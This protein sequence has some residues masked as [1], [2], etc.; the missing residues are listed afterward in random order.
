MECYAG[1]KLVLAYTMTDLK[2]ISFNVR[3]L[4]QRTKRRA[5]FH[6]LHTVYQSHIVVLQETHSLPSDVKVWK[7]EWGGEIIFAHSP[8]CNASGV[9]V[10]LPRSRYTCASVMSTDCDD[11]GRFVIADIKVELVRIKLIAVYAPTKGHGREQISFYENIR[12][13]LEA[14]S[15]DEL[16]FAVLCG[17]CNVHLSRLDVATPQFHLTQAAETLHAILEEFHLVDVWRNLHPDTVQCTWRR[18]EPVQQS[19][20]DYIFISQHLIENHMVKS[21]DISPGILSDHSVVT[22]TTLLVVHEKGPGLWRFNNL[23]LEDTE[24]VLNAKK[25]MEQAC[26]AA[27]TYESVNDLGLRLEVMSGQVRSIAIRR[28]KT[29]ARAKRDRIDRITK[30]KDALE[31]ELASNPSPEVVAGYDRARKEMDDIQEENGKRAMLFSGARWFEH[32]ERPTKYFLGLCA[33]RKAGRGITVLQTNDGQFV[34]DGKDILRQC[35]KHFEVIYKSSIGETENRG[36]SNG[37]TEFRWPACPKL[38]DLDKASCDGRITSEECIEALKSMLNNKSP[39]VSGFSK[40]FFLFFWDDLGTLIVDYINEARRK[41]QFFVTQRRGVITLIPKKGDQTLIRN[42]RAIC[43]LDTVYKIVAKVLATRLARVMHCLV[44][45]DQT[46]A[47]RN[48]FIGTNL[49]TIADVIDLCEREKED[50]ILMALDFKDAFNSVEHSFVYETLRRFNFGDDFVEWVK[51]L[52]SGSELSIINNGHTSDWFKPAKGLQQGCPISAQ[53]FA[54][55]VEVLALKIKACNTV[56]P[57]RWRNEIYRIT[58]YCDDTTVF[59]RNTNSAEQVCSIVQDFGNVSGLSLNLD[60]CN[61]MWLGKSKGSRQSICGREPVTAVKI[62]GVWFS[63]LRDCGTD[64]VEPIIDKIKR[65]LNAWTQRDLTIKG[66]ITIAKSLLVSQLTYVMAVGGIDKVHIQEIQ[67]LI[68]RF[69]WKGKP[70]KV[71]KAVLIQGVNEGGLNAPDINTIY[72]AHRVAWLARMVKN[73]E[74][75]FVKI[76]LQRLQIRSLNDLLRSHYSNKWI[77]GLNVSSFYK[78]MLM[79]YAEIVHRAEP[80]TAKEVRLQM[81][82]HNDRIQ[83]GRKPLFNRALAEKGIW[84]VDDFL[85]GSGRV[86]KY[87]EFM[88]RYQPGHINPLTYIGWSRAIPTRWKALVSG[89]VRL[90]ESEKTASVAIRVNDK[91]VPLNILRTRHF[92]E[93]QRSTVTPTAQRRWEADGINFDDCWQKVYSLPFKVTRSTRLQSLQYRIAHRYFPTKRYLFN[94]QIAP[95]PFCDDCGEV[96]SL[97]HYFAMCPQLTDFWTTFSHDVNRKLRKRFHFRVTCENVLFGCLNG[98]ASLNV[99]ILYAKQFVISQKCHGDEVVYEGFR[100]YIY[101]MFEVEKCAARENAKIEIFRR[102]WKPFISQ[103]LQ[104]QL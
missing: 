49:R 35:K 92:Y 17:D 54:L 56:E 101:K 22:L 64:N 47:I 62:L 1:F 38:S 40:E 71:A 99:V 85:D 5:I 93:L 8:S 32:G 4:R 48:R 34:T 11:D 60:K 69:I 77:K 79:W 70:P 94:V 39:S 10:L 103:S 76:L 33:K 96:D 25:E 20:I 2:L 73:S 31:R 67:K 15:L 26:E 16:K 83:V 61:F 46:G 98:P 42:K 30:T 59:V 90:D 55:V 28:S 84:F 27:G 29:I 66:R 12:E 53:L 72:R 13:K 37:R 41:G 44:S 87:H 19:R 21:A 24:F 23:L 9:A 74:M 75:T 43:L 81:I 3:G 95:D 52:H 51:L 102:S 89:S 63:A 68:M 57:I 14:F 36:V 91:E 88:S 80:V 65:T 50:G 104:L 86:L 7:A 78:E 58:Q 82:W 45:D 18:L 97:Q 6:F 100:N